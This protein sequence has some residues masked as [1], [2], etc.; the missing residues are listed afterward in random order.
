MHFS[1]ALKASNPEVKIDASLHDVM[2]RF[3]QIIDETMHLFEQKIEQVL[4]KRPF[5]KKK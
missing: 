1:K 2:Q 3:G 4:R 5:S